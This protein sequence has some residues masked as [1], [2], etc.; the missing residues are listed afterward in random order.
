MARTST[1]ES[2]ADNLLAPHK[3]LYFSHH[4]D[5]DVGVCV[6][7]LK[8][9]VQCVFLERAPDATDVQLAKQVFVVC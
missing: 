3:Q 2:D 1:I 6:D 5:K 7:V 4:V 9:P 8:R